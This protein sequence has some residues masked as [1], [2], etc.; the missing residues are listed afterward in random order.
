[1]SDFKVKL[2]NEGNDLK[3][4]QV[5]D[6]LY[7]VNVYI[8]TSREAGMNLYYYYDKGG[9]TRMELRFLVSDPD[10]LETP[11]E[12]A[13]FPVKILDNDNIPQDLKVILNATDEGRIPLPV[14]KSESRIII[15][16]TIVG[17]PDGILTIGTKSDDSL[18][19]R[20]AIY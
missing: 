16:V 7:A 2:F 18:F 20:K 4:Q 13:N 5:T 10:F 15:E 11:T 1:M 12:M 8:N 9:E 6:N 3:I 14:A 17:T 19:R